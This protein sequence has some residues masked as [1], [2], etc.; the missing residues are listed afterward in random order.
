MAL[1]PGLYSR[2]ER[3]NIPQPEAVFDIDYFRRNPATFY[4]VSKEL[5]PNNL[6]PTNAHYF[7][8]LLAKENLLLRVYTQNVDTLERDAGV[9]DDRIVEAHGSF[10]TASCLKCHAKYSKTYLKEQ[11]FSTDKEDFVPRCTVPTCDGVIKPDI[12]VRRLAFT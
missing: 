10:A 7:I 8:S 2:L 9:P 4:Q 3:Y 5:I 12:T 6:K 11:I 1:D